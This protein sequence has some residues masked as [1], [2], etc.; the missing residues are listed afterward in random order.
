MIVLTYTLSALTVFGIELTSDNWDWMTT[1]K[2]VFIKFCTSSFEYSFEYCQSM[3]PA[4][5]QLMEDYKKRVDILIAEVDCTD[6]KEEICHNLGI[7]DYPSLKYGDPNSSLEDYLGEYGYL[8]LRKFAKEHFGPTCGIEH[9]DLCDYDQRAKIE[10]IRAKGLEKIE[11]EVDELH[12]M[13]ESAEAH[14]SAEEAKLEA[15][16]EKLEKERDEAIDAARPKNLVLMEIVREYLL[17]REKQ[18]K[19]VEFHDTDRYDW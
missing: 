6:D 9:L 14:F 2:A 19:E 3:K 18:E 4:W 10:E 7:N 1:G 17:P 12:N 13:I 15:T 16:Y 11:A 8:E 5:D